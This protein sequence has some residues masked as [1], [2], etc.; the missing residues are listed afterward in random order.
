LRQMLP[1]STE[2]LYSKSKKDK[3]SINIIVEVLIKQNETIPQWK[4]KFLQ[5]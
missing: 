5:S 4:K 1:M 2:M 3:N